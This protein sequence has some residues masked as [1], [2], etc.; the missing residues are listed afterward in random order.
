LRRNEMSRS[1]GGI[2][3]AA[4]A[5]VAFALVPA[6]AAADPPQSIPA[7]FT[8]AI[9]VGAPTASSSS[10]SWTDLGP[11]PPSPGLTGYAPT[12][13]QRLPAN[14]DPRDLDFIQSGNDSGAN[15]CVRTLA[16]PGFTVSCLAD[17]TTYANYPEF[18]WWL[19]MGCKILKPDGGFLCGRYDSFDQHPDGTVE[20]IGSVESDNG[21][22]PSAWNQPT[23]FDHPAAVAAAQAG[24]EAAPRCH[25]HSGKSSRS[26]G[27]AAS[28]KH[29]KKCKRKKKHH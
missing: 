9:T 20:E 27:A 6:T 14:A 16:D 23:C 25:K 24:A 19:R 15:H 11:Q 29:H 3:V 26:S 22:T 17:Y 21:S 1:S 8:T 5:A 2:L 12:D 28:R 10:C 7:W 4:L 18:K 13:E